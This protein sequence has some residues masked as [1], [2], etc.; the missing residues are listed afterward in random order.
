MREGKSKNSL[1][2]TGLARFLTDTSL[3]R[4]DQE[5]A[6]S[7]FYALRQSCYEGTVYTQ[8]QNLV[9]KHT[10]APTVLLN[11]LNSVVQ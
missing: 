4:S 8:S 1:G 9:D 3:T 10:L 2:T 5:M 11:E 6:E 7:V